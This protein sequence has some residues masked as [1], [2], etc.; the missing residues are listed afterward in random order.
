MLWSLPHSHVFTGPFSISPCP[1]P[2][3]PHKFQEAGCSGTQYGRLPFPNSNL[4]DTSIHR[5]DDERSL[6]TFSTHSHKAL[7]HGR[8]NSHKA[9]H[10]GRSNS[11]TSGRARKQAGATQEGPAASP[12]PQTARSELSR[13]RCN[14][15]ALS[16]FL[17]ALLC[18]VT[19]VRLSS[20]PVSGIK[21]RRRL[22]GF[23][24]P[25]PHPETSKVEATNQTVTLRK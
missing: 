4:R 19:S 7:R 9:L 22:Q 10:H 23:P 16:C 25:H 14:Q 12:A 1:P 6:K 3:P 15:P 21:T 2:P 24:T 13:P 8:S 11:Q 20:L 18:E 5:R 17:G